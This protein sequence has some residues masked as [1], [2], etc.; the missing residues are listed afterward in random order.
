MTELI[1]TALLLAIFGL[2]IAASVLSSRA[3]ERMG[4]PVVLLFLVLGMLGGSEGIGGIEFSDYRLAFRI[5][6][7][8]LI[9]ILL[10]GGLNT[11]LASIKESIRP[12][13]V[14]ATF[15]VAGTA[16]LVAVFG[17]WTGLSW[18][19][20]LLLGAVVSSTDAA[21][22]FAVLRGGSLRL[23]R[24][25]GTTIELESGVNDPMAVILTLGV[26]SVLAGQ[27]V[28]YGRLALGVPLQLAIGLVV[29]AG[30][31]VSAKW[32]LRSLRLSTAGLYPVLV[33]GLAFLSFGVATLAHGSGFLAVYVTAVVIGNSRVPFHSGLVRIHDAIGWLSQISMFLVLGLLVFPSQLR[34]IAGVGIAV[35][36]FMAF[37]ARPVVVALCLLPFGFK[38]KEIAYI[39]WVGLKG[40]VPIILATFPVLAGTPE[41]MKV[42]NIVFF[43]V[44][45]NA[46]VPG[47]TIRFLTRRLGLEALEAP[48]PIAALE[49]NST[50]LLDGELLSFTITEP[51]AVCNVPLSKI[52]WPHNSSAVLL[53]R[54]EHL[55]APRGSTVLSPGDHVYIFCRT[56]DKPFMQFL[57]GRPEEHL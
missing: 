2:L 7:A 28:S 54:G 10:D 11:P 51:L 25:V 31:G 15:G 12:A 20:C 27:T 48:P 49:I 21:A 8:A 37:I 30:F 1:A 46:L 57:F 36:L 40:A 6:T 45:C 4:V 29:G 17:H 41:G 53:V 50:R 47:A 43:V 56:E 33:L 22:V 5:G 14:L 18:S 16:G 55:I 35:A 38:A 34:P 3:I 24:R 42:F 9:L 39:G 44:V 26:I 52:P 32:L 23:T 19:E 13:G